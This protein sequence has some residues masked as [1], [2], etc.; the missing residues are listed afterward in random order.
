MTDGP[1]PSFAKDIRPLF[2]D[3]D[4]AHMKPAGLDLSN[5]DDVA[6]HADAILNTVKSGT[7]PPPSSGEPRWTGEMVALFEKWKAG[8]C[9]P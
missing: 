6:K 1:A 8:G 3:M 5:R 2:T 9:L 4:I 7:M